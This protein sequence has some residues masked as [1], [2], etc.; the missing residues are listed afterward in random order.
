MLSFIRKA[1]FARVSSPQIRVIG[2]VLSFG[3]AK[4]MPT[5]AAAWIAGGIGILVTEKFAAA[6]M[7]E[8]GGL[9]GFAFKGSIRQPMDASYREVPTPS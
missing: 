2:Y 8:E 4:V 7:E 1:F 6:R 3:I 9:L 5:N